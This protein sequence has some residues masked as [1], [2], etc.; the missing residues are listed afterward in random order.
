M[1]SWTRGRRPMLLLIIPGIVE[2]QAYVYFVQG[3]VRWSR[4][5]QA[6]AA[7]AQE[8]LPIQGFSEDASLFLLSYRVLTHCMVTLR[9]L[10]MSVYSSITGRIE[11]RWLS[12]DVLLLFYFLHHWHWVF[13][14]AL[15]ESVVSHLFNPGR[16]LLSNVGYLQMSTWHARAL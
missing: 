3:L 16:R 14:R 7:T 9:W 5:C 15:C 8:A 4:L 12:W 1:K 6:H 2:A 13:C 10:T 11:V